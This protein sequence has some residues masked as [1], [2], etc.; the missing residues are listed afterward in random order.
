MKKVTGKVGMFER[1]AYAGGDTASNLFWM[2]FIF[3]INYFY[4]DVFKLK[5]EDMAAMFLFV[6]IIDSVTDPIVGILADRTNTKWGKFR[7]YILWFAIPFAIIGWLTLTTPEW[8]YGPKLAYAY[9]TYSLMMLVYTLV[10]IPYSSLLGVI[11]PNTDERTAISGLRFVFAQFGGI[12]VQ[13]LTIYLVA[14]Y[15]GGGGEGK[16]IANEAQGYSMTALTFAIA[17]AALFFLTFFATRERISPPKEQKTNLKDDLKDLVKNI[18]WWILFAIGVLLIA[19]VCIRNGVI[20]YYFKYYAESL[21]LTIFGSSFDID[22]ASTYM[23]V[24]TATS[25]FA[26]AILGWL[27]KIFKGKKRMFIILMGATVFL[28]IGSY[29]VPKDAI[30]TMFFYQIVISLATGP[31]GAIVWAMYADT[32]DYSEH[33]NGRRATGLVFS[34]ATA[35]QKMGWTIGGVLIGALLA[36]FNYN[37]DNITEETGFVMRLLISVIPAVAA[38]LSTI[39]MALYPL[40]DKR[41][42]EIGEELDARRE[43]TE[44]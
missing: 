6:R 21:P 40:S 27:L 7:P 14:Y 2:F 22:L 12:L 41:M 36:W 31:L 26:N 16:E 20:I 15:G 10:N 11:S 24:G 43:K 37:P 25:L 33:K 17:A 19:F 5:P 32:A 23:I 28:S 8:E 35:S 1:F 9:I 29:F 18:P 44:I 39:A 4:T 42:K 13:A 38:L 30:A 3:Y 34:A